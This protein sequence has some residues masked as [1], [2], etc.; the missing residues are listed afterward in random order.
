[1]DE[2]RTGLVVS[3]AVGC[4]LMA[5]IYVTFSAI[6]MPS[7]RQ[8]PAAEGIGVMQTINVVIVNP[9]FLLLFLGTAATSLALIVVALRS[10]A[11]V[12]HL[13]VVAAGA[14]YLIG[15]IVVTGVANVPR[16]DALDALDPDGVGAA[17]AW[18][19]YLGGWTAWNHVR[20]VSCSAALVLLLV[21][22]ARA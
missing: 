4:G 16:N 9:L 7:L 12:A 20:S 1:M 8:R 17:D 14:L 21:A 10:P 19:R 5:G 6:V 18:S 22:L 13:D 15:S 2:V 3:T 11:P